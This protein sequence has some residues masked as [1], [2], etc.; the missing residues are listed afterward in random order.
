MMSTRPMYAV[1]LMISCFDQT[2]CPN[3]LKARGRIP[4]DTI[5]N[6]LHKDSLAM[7]SNA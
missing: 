6:K 5:G 2:S 1:L 4:L 3:N 7:M